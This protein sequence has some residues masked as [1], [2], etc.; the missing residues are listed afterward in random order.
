MGV[1]YL[2]SLLLL[3]VAF[4]PAETPPGSPG[5]LVRRVVENELKAENQDHSHWTF[6]LDSQ[7]P[8]GA[9]EA[10]EVVETKD[11][12]LQMPV[13]IDGRALSGKEQ[14]QAEKHL[15]QL[16]HHPDALQKSLN[17]K[18]EDTARSQRL[19]KMLPDAFNFTYGEHRNR[20]VELKFSPNPRFRAPNHEAQVFHAMQGSL[21]VDPK[22]ERVVEING[23]LMREV[24]FAGG[25]LGHLDPGGTFDVK[26]AEV[27]PGFWELTLLNVE[28][29]GKALFFKTI[30][31]HQKYSRT[32]FRRVSEALTPAQGLDLLRKQMAA[33]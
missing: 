12:D 18:S 32:E 22:N 14:R 7:R 11:G 26:Q 17:A 28:M 33:R 16:V 9:K 19:L 15:E 31:V 21:W 5:E 2:L 30:S 20:F 1:T 8:G 10:D 24:K 27:A 4:A 13:L 23:H 6:R 3:A 25:L 29:K